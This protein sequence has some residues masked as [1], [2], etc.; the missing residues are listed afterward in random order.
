[1]ADGN[2]EI[3]AKVNEKEFSNSL[4]RISSQIQKFGNSS[5]L[6]SLSNIGTSFLGISGAVKT[7]TGSVKAIVSQINELTEAY[8]KQAQAETQL[9][10]AAKNNPYLNSVSV[11]NLKNYASELQ[12]ISTYGDEQI[13]PLMAQ[14]ASAGRTQA[15]IQDIMSVSIDVAASGTMSLE[16]AVKNLNKTFSGLSGELGES[17]PQIKE[18]TA[19]QLKNGEGVKVL[20]SQYKGM[21]QNVA[22]STGGWTQF[23]NT[24]GDL[25]ELIGKSFAESKNSAGQIFNKFLSGI[26]SRM[27]EATKK[28]KELKKELELEVQNSGNNATVS[29]LK[30]EIALLDSKLEKYNKIKENL[31]ISQKDFVKDA[32]TALDEFSDEYEKKFS[33][34]S[35]KENEALLRYI[36]LLNNSNYTT[37]E[38]DEHK[39]AWDQ[40][41]KE[42]DKY[43]KT[44]ESTFNQLK[45]NLKTA[46]KEYEDLKKDG[47]TAAT[48][49]KRISEAQEQRS[50]AQKKLN[51]LQ[52][53]ED[54]NS[55]KNAL[56]K[57]IERRDELREAYDNTISAK[58]EEIRLRRSAGEEISKEAEAQEMYNTAFSEY[59]K[60][61]SDSA[62]K[63]NSGN[64]EHEVNARKN[65]ANWASI[66][67]GA[68]LENQIKDFETNIKKISDEI[69]GIAKNQYDVLL[70]SLNSEY[71]AVIENKYLEEEEKLRLE[72]EFAAI[73]EQ[74]VIEKNNAEKQSAIDK[75]DAVSEKEASWWDKYANQQKE[76]LELKQSVD[77]SE[78][79][80]T[81][82]KYEKMKELDEAYKQSKAS[83][84][85]ELATQIKNY[86]DQAAS[87]MNEAAALML[88]TVENQSTAEQAELELKYRK[89]EIGE[90]EY[91]EKITES[92]RKAA[93]EQYKIELWQWGASIL[94]ATANIAQGVS[95]AIA[96]GGVAGIITG[97]LVAAAGGVQLASIIA[98][99]PTPPS[100]S[101]GG[102]VGGRSYS[103]DNIAANLN[104]REMIMN[105]NQQKGLWNFINGGSK[106]MGGMPNIVINNSASNIVKAQP[107]LTKDKIEILID[108]RVNESLQNGRY[109]ASLNMAQQGMGGDYYGI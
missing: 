74:I 47:I 109:S 43:T 30:D 98:S 62:F 32:Q 44:N 83:Q 24:L 17:I 5:T 82:E 60:M 76:I 37:E 18:L 1:M 85:A 4:Q 48:I 25:K 77:E 27:S 89:G 59:I 31:N 51:E 75:I 39:Y 71:K 55:E 13:L 8:N 101:T 87:I 28:A 35:N 57:E 68:D 10:S 22:N 15:E 100:F 104:S 93:K 23:K 64:Y 19:E 46:K 69:Q 3:D 79:L 14:L 20:Q 40:A 26:V 52:Q 33:E 108:A 21:A 63:G 9:E 90:E 6:K 107:Q 105:M 106:G 42:L 41:T 103:G 70:E 38:I 66:G 97:A 81:E 72:K 58:K 65:I 80:S 45:E 11:Q 94:T 61:M 29:S 2:I 53:I 36:S 78:V 67:A 99:K 54:D 95:K 16:S 7:A 102:I 96:Q 12:S 92:K 88:E 56:L 86:T 84:I 73:R 50:V 49:E 91:N 34:L